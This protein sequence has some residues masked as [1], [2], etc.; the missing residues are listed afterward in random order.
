MG[1]SLFRF[2]FNTLQPRMAVAGTKFYLPTVLS[3]LTDDHGHKVLPLRSDSW[4]IGPLQDQG[5]IAV[6]GVFGDS[7][8]AYW[9]FLIA[10]HPDEFDPRVEADQFDVIETPGNDKPTLNLSNVTVDGLQNARL[11][12]DLVV[13]RAGSGYTSTVTI[14]FGTFPELPQEL[15]ITGDYTL[16]QSLSM[17]DEGTRTVTAQQ[18]KKAPFA[19]PTFDY[20]CAGTFS[21][22]VTT[23]WAEVDWTLEVD[24]Q[25]RPIIA[26]SRI[27][28]RGKQVGDDP[29]LTLGPVTVDKYDPGLQPDVLEPAV[30]QA[31]GDP[32][33]RTELLARIG[34][35]LNEQNNRDSLAREPTKNLSSVLDRSIGP[36][37]GGNTVDDSIFARFGSAVNNSASDYYLPAVIFGVTSP[38][39]DP[40]QLSSIPFQ[41][42]VWDTPVDVALNDCA[43]AGIADAIAPADDLVF[44]PGVTARVWFSTLP[45][46]STVRYRDAGGHEQTGT[47]TAP[48]RLTG[49]AV[50]TIEGQDPIQG[51]FTVTVA[52]A[53]ADTVLPTSGGA[54]NALDTLTIT[55]TSLSIDADPGNI[56]INVDIGDSFKDLINQELNTTENRKK[57]VDEINKRLGESGTLTDLGNTISENVRGTITSRLDG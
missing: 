13:A 30:T 36:A 57:I 16:T 28:L 10:R 5:A 3:G 55:C 29:A 49:T 42:E 11:E 21:L 43:L 15:T 56:D 54:H 2:V 14:A 35:T 31:F 18:E 47:L 23:L 34:E 24:G 20:S 22:F 9:S 19:W 52:S 6:A 8:K 17:A 37:A 38:K 39:L 44:D 45:D 41:V 48:L 26:I 32:N 7:F 4:P 40:Y 27:R 51:P 53:T 46:K 1:E 12:P 33:A 25:G 50:V